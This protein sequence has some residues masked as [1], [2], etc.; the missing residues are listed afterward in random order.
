MNENDGMEFRTIHQRR[1]VR[2]SGLKNFSK[3]T[4]KHVCWGFFNNVAG[5]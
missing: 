3:L 2:K 1:S 4:E 5:L